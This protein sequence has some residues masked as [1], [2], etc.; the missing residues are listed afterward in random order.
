M[1]V[2][3][4]TPESAEREFVPPDYFRVLER[5]EIFPDESRPLEVDLGC[6]DGAFL[7]ALAKEFP[8]RDFLGVERLLGRVRKVCRKAAREGLTNLKVLRLESNYTLGWLLPEAEVDRIHLLC[9]DPWP[10]AR[11]QN[12]RLVSDDFVAGLLRVLKPEG[13]FLFK[14]DHSEYFEEACEVIG[15]ASQFEKLGWPEDAFY[16]PRTDFEELW[17]SN[18]KSIFRSRW[19]LR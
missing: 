13:E 15:R 3:K 14:T 9:P 11:H 8:E 5:T 6:G 19:K 12:R 1:S 16:Y 18:G 7:L 4:H 10:K 17:T 2:K